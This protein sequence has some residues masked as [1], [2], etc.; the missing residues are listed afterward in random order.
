MAGNNELATLN[1]NDP[2]AIT[3]TTYRQDFCNVNTSLE[4]GGVGQGLAGKH[5]NSMIFSPQSDGYL[6]Y[7]PKTGID[8]NDP[9]FMANVLDTI[10][11]RGSFTWKSSSPS[12][13]SSQSD[14]GGTELGFGYVYDIHANE[15]EKTKWYTNFGFGDVYDIYAN[16]D[17]KKKTYTDFLMWAADNFDIVVGDWDI[18][19]E[20]I[21]DGVQFTMGI[22]EAD[23]IM[24]RN[25][26][27]PGFS[28]DWSNW[29]LPFTYQVWFVVLITILLSAVVYQFL[30]WMGRKREN[31][32]LRKW[33]ME[34]VYNSFLG[35][36]QNYSHEPSMLSTRFF[37]ISFTLWTM[38]IGAA[39]TA[40]LTQLLVTRSD[41]TF[42][43]DSIEDAIDRQMKIC[44]LTGSDF[45][46]YTAP[47]YP[48]VLDLLVY[49]ETVDEQYKA[50]NF[51]ECEV[52]MDYDHTFQ[53]HQLHKEKNPNC[54]L[55][56]EGRAVAT[57][58]Q[59][60]ATKFST[61]IV[62]S[63]VVNG[64]LQYHCC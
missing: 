62:C 45:V 3:N 47:K 28:V 50:L 21:N 48:A 18:T 20:R 58:K 15:D 37:G 22:H 52:L 4:N 57:L 44:V 8:K 32:S 33:T 10:A 16:K 54:Y 53:L 13:S 60:F 24:V 9:G 25:V 36:T 31:R 39:Y 23:L 43:L 49:R 41:S 63:D 55:K 34:N 19:P 1:Y 5:V 64:E 14:G 59:G 17:E 46:E 56:R 2:F 11:D 26:I 30:E 29:L 35:F 61:G 51:G 12:S 42:T 38:L 6:N 27:P 7:D 40:N